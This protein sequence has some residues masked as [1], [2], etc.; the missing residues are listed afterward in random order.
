M[1][2][3]LS[4]PRSVYVQQGNLLDAL[5]FLSRTLTRMEIH[6][7]VTG[8]AALALYGYSQ[9]VQMI[10]LLVTPDGLQRIQKILLNQRLT[11]VD[12]DSHLFWDIR[13]GY[14][15]K[16]HVV[17]EC[18]NYHSRLL[19]NMEVVTLDEVP[20]LPLELLLKQRIKCKIC[21]LTAA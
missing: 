14:S 11:I 20:T 13:T 6:H 8:A 7:V 4:M 18:S 9:R 15:I 12:V 10:D 17:E 19:H 5:I 16:L 1:T 3:F 21:S 2:A